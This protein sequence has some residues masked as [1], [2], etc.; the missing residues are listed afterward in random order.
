M[1]NPRDAVVFDNIDYRAETFAIDNSTITYSATVAGGSSQVGLAVVP[2]VG[3]PKTIKLAEDGEGPIMKLIKVEADGNATVQV[4][5]YAELP[6]GDSATLTV[7]EKIVGDLG[8]ANAKGYIRAVAT[9]T[10]AELGHARGE[11]RDA[12]VTTAV[13]VRLS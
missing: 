7:G 2:V 12:S 10:A 11:I 5:G 8:A 9:G 4:E 6:G 3:T 13:V 1:A